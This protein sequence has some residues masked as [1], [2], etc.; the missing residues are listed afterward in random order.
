MNLSEMARRTR[1]H[2]RAEIRQKSTMGDPLPQPTR[3]IIIPNQPSHGLR[4]AWITDT[5][6]KPGVPTD[7]IAAAGKYCARKRPDVIVFAGDW[8]DLPSLSTWGEP[9]SLETENL[10]YREDIDSG[11]KAMED[12]HEPIAKEAGYHPVE[13]FNF[14]NH[15]FRQQR[16]I[17]AD[18]QKLMGV[19]S[20]ADFGLADYGIQAFP[21]LQPVTINGVAFCHFFPSGVMGRPINTARNL[22]NKLHMSACAGHQQGRQIEYG[23]RADGGDLTAIISGSFY[24]HDESYLNPF[25]NHHWRGFYMLNEVRDGSFDEMAISISFLKR[26]FG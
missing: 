11:K 23:K 13:V 6:V 4:I 7:H 3:E 21:F 22:L 10:R 24:Q 2:R 12:F 16:A 14:G 25:T 5:Q 18:P 26:K 19:M 9:G 17:A 20:E 1:S 8:W 15:C